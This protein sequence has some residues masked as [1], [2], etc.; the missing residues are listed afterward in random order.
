MK[1]LLERGGK[2]KLSFEEY[3][4]RQ[5]KAAEKNQENAAFLCGKPLA[6]TL[7]RLDNYLT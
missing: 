2:D 3:M 5:N 7:C 1:S 4:L 6:V